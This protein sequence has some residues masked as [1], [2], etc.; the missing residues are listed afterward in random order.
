MAG[1]WMIGVMVELAGEPAPLRHYF[2]IG[3]ED[4]GKSEWTAVDWAGRAGR[5]ADGLEEV[6]VALEGCERTGARVGIA[7]LLRIKGDLVLMQ[8]ERE[9]TAAAEGCFGEA[10]EWARR[11]GAL[12]WELRTAVSLARLRMGQDRP[13]EAREREVRSCRLHVDMVWLM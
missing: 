6:P 10:L 4:Q 2:A 13:R 9:A 11:Q 1:G 7:E 3:H 8:G 5:V 12:S